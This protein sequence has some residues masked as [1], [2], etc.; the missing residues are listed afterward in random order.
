MKVGELSH[1]ETR[2][3]GALDGET[4]DAAPQVVRTRATWLP[5]S[6]A[7]IPDKLVAAL[8]CGH[9]LVV[10]G[11]VPGAAGSI[12]AALLA[13][14]FPRLH[15][16]GFATASITAPLSLSVLHDAIREALTDPA[17]SG[18]PDPA[19]PLVVAIEHAE[20]LLLPTIQRLVELAAL[21][22][23]AKPV[24]RFL[25]AGTDAVWPTLRAAG[26]A[27]L[28]HDDTG[29]L[30]PGPEPGARAPGRRRAPLP[31]AQIRP[32][33]A[34]RAGWRGPG[35]IQARPG[36]L[37]PGWVLVLV[38][39][40]GIAI[41]AAGS[42]AW[43]LLRP[44][45]DVSA[46]A[47]NA[48]LADGRLA[49][50][51]RR[52]TAELAGSRLQSPPGDNLIETRRQIAA[53]I[54]TLS[55]DGLRRLEAANAAVQVGV[56]SQA[57]TRAPSPPAPSLQAPS[58]QAP[59]LPAPRT[60][61]APR[62]PAARVPASL[63]PAAGAPAA[64]APLEDPVHVTVRY[65]RL[66]AGAATRAAQ[67]LARLRS[68]GMLAD[69]PV[70]LDHPVAHPGVAYFFTQDRSAADQ[71]AQRLLPGSQAADQRTAPR[72]LLARPG[73][74]SITIGAGDDRTRKQADPGKQT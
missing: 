28:E 37:G 48:A 68:Q 26:L 2:T 50:L 52:Q 71:L 20:N 42:I 16:A 17:L 10:L 49:V 3:G 59:S 5:E 64:S 44:Q 43:V 73:E 13:A 45:P 62:L 35:A 34:D 22:R 61:A 40:G 69:G 31:P 9:D 8:S 21:R 32:E 19:Q 38:A 63:A 55:P 30:R 39:V 60:P 41:A 65:D 11:D 1:Q 46:P 15:E 12:T 24:L 47:T 25:L 56:Q 18:R 7:G 58:L 74:I 6:A 14:T 57:A 54:P 53:L 67:I 36:R 70:A 4:R 66:D 27:G 51:L 29:H 72:G 33:R 23:D